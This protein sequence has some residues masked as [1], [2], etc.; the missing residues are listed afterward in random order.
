MSFL[1]DLDRKVSKF[2]L[3]EALQETNGK[4][5]ENMQNIVKPI[6]DPKVTALSFQPGHIR[7]SFS[8]LFK[9]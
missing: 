4:L 3:P 6:Q 9:P 7:G 2:E 8:P 1:Q 5:T